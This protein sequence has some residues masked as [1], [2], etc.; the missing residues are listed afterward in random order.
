MIT[1]GSQP[2]INPTSYLCF[3]HN[4]EVFLPDRMNVCGRNRSVLMFSIASDNSSHS[5]L[6]GNLKLTFSIKPFSCVSPVSFQPICGSIFS[7]T[8]LTSHFCSVALISDKC[9]ADFL[10]SKQLICFLTGMLKAHTHFHPENLIKPYFSFS[11]PLNHSSSYWFT[12]VQHV[13]Y[14]VICQAIL[15]VFVTLF[16][17]LPVS[18]SF[19][20]N[21]N[22]IC[23]S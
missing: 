16:D 20:P 18:K 10:L 23:H 15:S 17:L 21:Q 6:Y 3:A 8:G 11:A 9:G 13:T 1:T 12:L 22:L 2:L 14:N 5:S 19:V 7:Q 4:F